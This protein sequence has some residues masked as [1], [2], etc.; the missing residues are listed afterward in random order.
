MPT[1]GGI[2]AAGPPNFWLALSALGALVVAISG[3]VLHHFSEVM[4]SGMI[5]LNLFG[6][7]VALISLYELALAIGDRQPSRWVRMVELL[8]LALTLL[9]LALPPGLLLPPLF[10]ASMLFLLAAFLVALKS[11]ASGNNE[12]RL[13][14][15]ALIIL[16]LTLSR[17]VLAVA[18]LLPQ[19]P[20][21]PILSF[22]LL[23]L[24]AAHVL[25][26]RYDREYS[27]L[28]DLRNAL[29]ARVRERTLELEA[30]NRRL[31]LLSRTD[32][33]TGLANRRS[34]VEGARGRLHDAPGVLVM[35]DIDFFKRIND[36]WGHMVGDDALRV[37]AQALGSPL[38]DN[39][40]L[41][42]WGGEEF[43]ALLEVSSLEEGAARA[44]EMR[45]AVAAATCLAEGER[46]PLSASFGLSL[47]AQGGDLDEAIGLA[48]E[49][50]YEAKRAGR[51]RVV[52]ADSPSTT[53]P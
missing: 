53:L 52:I 49:A 31:D 21:L 2:G 42:R 39:E 41:A 32:T 25:S 38:A 50:L 9:L 44:E 16:L 1:C 12:S 19:A 28:V 40:L 36:T 13:M 47:V 34:F 48:D 51:N 5:T 46:V 7:A 33:L 10:I 37:V 6:V 11:A 43:I 4:T 14:A 8:I 20:L 23:Y 45:A 26:L 18:G 3:L 15:V 17:D 29:E 30:V 35:T 22:A 27:E 24:A